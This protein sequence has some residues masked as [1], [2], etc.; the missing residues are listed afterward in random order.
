[1]ESDHVDPSETDGPPS[2]LYPIVL[3]IAIVSYDESPLEGKFLF[4]DDDG[5]ILTSDGE[6]GID[7]S[8]T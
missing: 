5:R 1:M 4:G 2:L 3:L 7:D 8:N 6:P